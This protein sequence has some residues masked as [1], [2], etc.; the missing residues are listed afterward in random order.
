VWKY[1]IF[2]LHDT[3]SVADVNVLQKEIDGMCRVKREDG[4]CSL[5]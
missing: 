4:G 3:P 2:C 5:N 1:I